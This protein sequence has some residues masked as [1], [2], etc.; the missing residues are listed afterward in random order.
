MDGLFY[1]EAT[2]KDARSNG[3]TPMQLTPGGGPRMERRP[4]RVELPTQED[5]QQGFHVHVES[6][7]QAAL[8]QQR[9]IVTTTGRDQRKSMMDLDPEENACDACV[10]PTS[11]S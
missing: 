11:A 4:S 1:V 6:I 8:G 7:G 10:P 9:I 2:P 5:E 3:T